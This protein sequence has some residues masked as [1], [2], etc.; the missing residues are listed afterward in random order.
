MRRSACALQLGADAGYANHPNADRAEQFPSIDNQT[1]FI[2]V[3][4]VGAYPSRA[5]QSSGVLRVKPLR[6]EAN[7]FVGD[8]NPA[9]EHQLGDV[10]YA[11]PV[12]LQNAMFHVAVRLSIRSR[13]TNPTTLCRSCSEAFG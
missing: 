8:L 9:S 13:N 5:P 6:P 2:Q 12:S 7:G 10:P 4:D 3:P 11:L 1:E